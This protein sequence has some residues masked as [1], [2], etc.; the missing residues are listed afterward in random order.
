M[1]TLYIYGPPASGKTYLAKKLEHAYGLEIPDLDAKIVEKI[2]MS[3]ADFFKLKGEGEFRR[4]ETETLKETIAPVV[5]LGGGTLLRAENRAFA[6]EHGLVGALTADPETIAARIAAQSGTRPLGNRAKERRVHYASFADHIDQDTAVLLP[7]KYRGRLAVPVSKSHYHRL[8]IA[9]FLAG[10]SAWAKS[11]AGECAD[12]EATRRCL[13][14]LAGNK[15]TT[16]SFEPILDCGESGSTLRFLAPVAAALGAKP[17]FIRRGRLAERPMIDYSSLASGRHELRGDISSQF[18]TGLLFALPLLNGDSEIVFTT[19]LQSRGYVDMTLRVIREYGI[20]VEETAYGFKVLGNQRFVSPGV[21]APEGDWS[22]AAFWYAAN[23]LGA[24]VEVTNLSDDSAQPDRAVKELVRRIASGTGDRDIDISGCPD[25]FPA[26]AGGAAATKAETRF[27]NAARL[28]IK[29][30]DRIEAMEKTLA[31][32]RV[33]TW[34][35]DDTVTVIGTDRRFAA[36]SIDSFN[37]HRIA[38]AAAVASIRSEG[39]VLV[40][41]AGSVAKSYPAFF[42]DMENLRVKN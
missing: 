34:S 20:E 17:Q 4:I 11:G 40:K 6:E 39:P 10:G 13:A 24:E 38:M 8:M 28:R 36:C 7:A 18:V 27:V 25:L 31:A 19:P 1:K 41:G 42:A 2:G 3:I 16:T 21:F 26:L 23:A 33:G 9:D 14:A 15:P 22:G 37:D 32:F 29:E 35:T 12:V 30:S 5:A